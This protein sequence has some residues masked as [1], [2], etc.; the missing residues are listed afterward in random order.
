M[1]R[2][3]DQLEDDG[4]VEVT[5][6]A[7]KSQRQEMADVGN[8]VEVLCFLVSKSDSVRREAMNFQDPNYMGPRA[9]AILQAAAARNRKTPRATPNESSATAAG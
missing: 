4:W 5:N 8:I 9:W 6:K 7:I 2:S 3:L 1:S